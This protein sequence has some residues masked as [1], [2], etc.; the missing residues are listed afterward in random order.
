[1]KKTLCILV[2]VFAICTICNAQ[3]IS[4]KQITRER[5]HA[6]WMEIG[7]LLGS[8]KYTGDVSGTLSNAGFKISFRW[9]KRYSDYFAMDYINLGL[10]PRFH[11]GEITNSNGKHWTP[12]VDGTLSLCLGPRGFFPLNYKNSLFVNYNAGIA[13]ISFCGNGGT[14]AFHQEASFGIEFH[15]RLA[16]SLFYENTPKAKNMKYDGYTFSASQ[17]QLGLRFGF[18]F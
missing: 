9:T 12:D 4:S 10:G 6:I 1:M 8:D 18:S 15:K 11:S 3:L 17:G 7:G 13:F 2:S 14:L 5:P 16:L